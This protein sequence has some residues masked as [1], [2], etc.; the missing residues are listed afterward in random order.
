M[1]A[2]TQGRREIFSVLLLIGLMLHVNI[3]WGQTLCSDNTNTV[4]GF[5]TAGGVYPIN[6]T[7]ATVGAAVGS[8]YDG[9]RPDSNANAF[10]YNS[11]NNKF[12][13]FYRCAAAVA[14]LSEFISYSA[15]T[16]TT[17]ILA[18]PPFGTTTKIRSG[19]V[20]NSGT[21]YYCF[22]IVGGTPS[23]WYYDIIA[24][25]WTKITS[26]FKKNGITDTTAVFQTLNSG[27][28][29]FDA[30]GNLWM[31]ISKSTQYAMYKILDPVPTTTQTSVAVKEIIPPTATPTRTGT[32]PN[33]ASFTGLAFN[34]NGIAFLTTGSGSGAANNQLYKMASVASGL[35]YVGALS[36]PA[37]G[38]GDDL[39]S[40]IYTSVLPVRWLDFNAQL[41][42][43]SGVQLSWDVA[44]DNTVKEYYVE[45]SI[46]ANKWDR[47]SVVS[48]KGT[49]DLPHI[50]YDYTDYDYLP[51]K[52]FY[53]IIGVDLYGFT[54][55]SEV[56]QVIAED[57][58]FAISPN[59]VKD[60]LTIKQ[61]NIRQGKVNI[62][63]SYGKLVLSID[64]S[65]S[66]ES[67][68]ISRLGKGNYFLKLS[69]D[70][71][72]TAHGSFIKL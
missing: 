13:G 6:V 42:K 36:T 41:K 14:P 35:V 19:C 3:G 68:D 10:G 46:N 15:T 32:A 63:D 1:K 55:T 69:V 22:D 24:N 26:T 37:L 23:L 31:V 28:M 58:N 39:T 40:C 65:Y 62:Y 53:R 25:T 71:I 72:Q 44:E 29:A 27:D 61:K 49:P 33:Q 43:Q 66:N 50:Q 2:K 59:P 21:G 64:V 57:V 51:G 7:S 52:T 34:S 54:R 12:Y 70:G 8:I 18:T 16:N 67:I 17:T 30:S 9:I 60:I 56:K 38:S 11:I 20:N 48:R 47:L 4:Y 45:R 5:S